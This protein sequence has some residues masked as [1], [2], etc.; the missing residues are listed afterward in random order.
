[1]AIA[2]QA[3]AAGENWGPNKD[4]YAERMVGNYQS[5]IAKEM[6]DDQGRPI[7]PEL[8]PE[9]IQLKGQVLEAMFKEQLHQS[10]WIS[11]IG[12]REEGAKRSFN[13]IFD[14]PNE[15]YYSKKGENWIV[16]KRPG[17]KK[18]SY[19]ENIKL[20]FDKKGLKEI[21]GFTIDQD[22]LKDTRAEWAETEKKTKEVSDIFSS[23][24]Y[25]G[26]GALKNSPRPP[27]FEEKV[28]F[29]HTSMKLPRDLM[30]LLEKKEKL[31]GLTVKEKEAKDELVRLL[32]NHPKTHEEMFRGKNKVLPK[33][34]VFLG[35]DKMDKKT[36]VYF[37]RK[38]PQ[39]IYEIVTTESLKR[40]ETLAAFS[41]DGFLMVQQFENKPIGKNY[42]VKEPTGKWVRLDSR[43]NPFDGEPTP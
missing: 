37:R 23:H 43:E 2:P 27:T 36:G 1:M 6:E 24:Y 39:G 19:A 35:I 42:S 13:A 10:L 32:E 11:F 4:S 31:S 40:G 41:D 33:F 18:Y 3:M 12:N 20:V 28:W 14:Y 22:K 8:S 17:L 29:E 15:F 21:N 9:E 16:Q 38:T 25:Y 7:G 26:I 5:P 30:F 34:Y